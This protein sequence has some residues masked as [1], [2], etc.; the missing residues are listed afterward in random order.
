MLAPYAS[1]LGVEWLRELPDA[2]VREVEGTLAFFDVSGFTRLS[3]RLT[4]L[5]K[6]GGEE[7][8]AIVDRIFGRLLGI[9]LEH[10]GDLLQFSGDAI[11]VLFRGDQHAPH[12]CVA[13]AQMQRALGD[14][15]RIDTDLGR[16]RLRMSAGMHSDTFTFLALGEEQR[17]LLAVGPAATRT[18]LL[19]KGANA[20][21]VLVGEATAERADSR[22]FA[23]GRDG[24]RLLRIGRAGRVDMS[25]PDASTAG[26][27]TATDIDVTRL[28][29][30]PFRP[31]LREGVG[32][33]EHRQLT[34]AFVGVRDLDARVTASPEECAEQLNVLAR[35][36]EAIQRELEITWTGVDALPGACDFFLVAG[37]PAMHED[38]E[39]RMLL[40]CRRL[41]EMDLGLDVAAG[42]NRGQRVCRGH[43][44]PSPPS[45][46]HHR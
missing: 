3:E 45:A 8:T 23:D 18:F 24:S 42:V 11:L 44:T 13:A 17:H 35:A 40:A 36:V 26:D 4:R 5:G 12:A 10:G 14:V 2:P 21:E 30:V 41:V 27:P 20:G 43:R 33:G 39:D 34:C 32:V 15:G 19:E 29:Q 25:S 37:A 22:W 16:T 46:Q 31:M 9:A 1:R 38:D 28:V 7:I 6:L